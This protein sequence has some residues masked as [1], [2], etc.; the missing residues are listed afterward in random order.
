MIYSAIETGLQSVITTLT[1]FDTDN[2]V[3]EKWDD[4]YD[5]IR[6]NGERYFC[7]LNLLGG[8]RDPD[9]AF[10]SLHMKWNIL[11]TFFIEYDVS[12]IATDKRTLLHD[13]MT[14]FKADRTLGS[15]TPGAWIDQVRTFEDVFEVGGVVYAPVIFVVVAKEQI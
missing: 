7:V 3:I 9:A 4:A 6:D 11:V 8:D 5:H 1:D 2:C 12:T 10:A 14:A 15:T 13:F